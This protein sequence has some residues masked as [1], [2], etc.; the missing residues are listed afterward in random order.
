MGAAELDPV[1]RPAGAAR[2]PGARRPRPRRRPGAHRER[3]RPGSA[4]HDGGHLGRR[5]AEPFPAPHRHRGP[6]R[7]GPR[8]RHRPERS[9]GAAVRAA[10]DDDLHR[11]RRR[12]RCRGGRDPRRSLARDAA[13]RIPA[14]PPAARPAVRAARRVPVGRVV[15]P[16]P[17]GVLRRLH[18]SG[19][20]RPLRPEHRRPPDAVPRPRGERQPRR[21]PLAP[22][23]WRRPAHAGGPYGRLPLRLHRPAMDH[24]GPRERPPPHGSARQRP[25]LAQP[26]PRPAG[27]R[28]RLLRPRPTRSATASRSSRPP[29]GSS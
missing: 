19:A 15:R 2:R 9:R 26:R 10:L 16:R 14:H 5:G 25:G 21:D 13:R 12:S 27:A 29:S 6:R 17:G 23:H 11:P 18:R 7:R 3:P 22:R 8:P 4:Q 28:K 1:F 24:R 20:R